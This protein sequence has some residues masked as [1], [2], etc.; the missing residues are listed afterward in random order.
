MKRRAKPAPVIPTRGHIPRAAAVEWAGVRVDAPAS[1]TVRG[2]DALD[3]IV[4]MHPPRVVAMVPIE[5]SAPVTAL[6]DVLRDALASSPEARPHRV[7]VADPD[8]VPA[9]A[10]V[11]G[12]TIPLFVAPVPEA[13][14]VIAALAA[15]L[16]RETAGGEPLEEIVAVAKRDPALVARFFAAAAAFYRL[17]PWTLV[18]SDSDVLRVDAP[19]L[20]LRDSCVSVIGQ[21]RESYGVMCF[22]SA[23]QFMSFQR[24]AAREERSDLGADLPPFTVNFASMR[25]MPP[26]FVRE[27]QRRRWAVAAPSGVPWLMCSS[28]EGKPRAISRDDVL[29]ASALMEVLTVFLAKHGRAIYEE[30]ARCEER[31]EVAVGPRRVGVSVEHPHPAYEDDDLDVFGDDLD[32]DD[33]PEP[34]VIARFVR[35][36]QDRFAEARPGELEAALLEA[37]S[38]LLGRPFTPADGPGASEHLGTSLVPTWTVLYRPGRDGRAGV[39]LLADDPSADDP[40]RALTTTIARGRVVL[41]DVIAIDRAAG[42]ALIEDV[43][44]H[45]R[46]T[47]RDWGDATLAKLTRWTR[48]F[49]LIVPLRDGGWYFPSVFTAGEHFARVDPARFVEAVNAALSAL[50]VGGAGVDPAAPAS[51]LRSHWGVAYGVLMRMG[52]E[53]IAA[54]RARKVFLSTSEGDCV[55]FHE[56]V[57]ALKATVGAVAARM[58]AADDMESTGARAWSWRAGSTRAELQGEESIATLAREGTRWVVRA[59][60]E[61]RLTRMLDRVAAIVGE[62]PREVSRTVSAPWREQ[63]NVVRTKAEASETM[64]L[65]GRPMAIGAGEDGDALAAALTQR[66]MRESLDREV[67]VVGGVP[68][69]RVATA[70][71]RAAVEAWLRDIERKGQPGERAGERMLDLDDLR[72]ELGLPTVG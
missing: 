25:E 1:M 40:S 27:L 56:V 29:A 57:I 19:A 26:A 50:K 32:D 43:Y 42:T 61:P 14:P 46:Y 52:D 72:R 8:A 36:W 22:E 71:G 31:Y 30:L 62:R 17:A 48:C 55:E 28:A 16:D 63:P 20:G 37:G 33:R 35:Q 15:S 67:P 58:G 41:G 6:A 38:A 53:V 9:V 12:P 54:D 39:E 2:V 13:A 64:V 7:R 45:A 11:M 49:G 70:E 66:A 3:L 10:A 18:P 60:S 5:R 47:L 68:R 24:R 65:A 34:E 23:E 4:W 59:S 44:D 69:A 21:A 51:G